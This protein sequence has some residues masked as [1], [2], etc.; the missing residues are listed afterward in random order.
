MVNRP[1]LSEASFRE[2][3]EV[4]PV[5]L[6]TPESPIAA[7]GIIYALKSKGQHY[8]NELS[9]PSGDH[10]INRWDPN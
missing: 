10:L 5:N 2:L 7:D 4:A 3:C 9:S 1:S 6:R 8:H